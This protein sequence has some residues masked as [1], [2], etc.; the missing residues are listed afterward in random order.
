MVVE[1]FNSCEP[2]CDQ[3][4]LVFIDGPKIVSL[5]SEG[6]SASDDVDVGGFLNEF[7][8]VVAH[9]DVMIS[10]TGWSPFFCFW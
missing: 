9:E 6:P 5:D 10:F 1:A 8:D 2:L 4:C 3:S 7:P